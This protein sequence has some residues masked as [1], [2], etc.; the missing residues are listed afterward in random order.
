MITLQT[1]R[2]TIAPLSEEDAAF[3]LELVNDAD[4]LRFIGDKRIHTL[5]AAARYL[6]EGPLAS[7]VRHGFGLCRVDRRDDRQPI[8]LC[9]LVR[10]S[11]LDDVDL[12][13]AFLPHGRG[14][15]FAHEAAAAVLAHGFDTLGYERIVAITT[16]DNRSSARVLES[17]GMRF[18]RHVQLPGDA[19]ALRLFA[20]ARDRP[21]DPQQ[22]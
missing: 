9:G 19:A 3:I 10:R 16:D 8:G 21:S 20:A 13:F 1:P 15:G 18:E 12:G 4:W 5:D 6:R 11:T 22:P 7:Y 14:Q 17:I 2:L